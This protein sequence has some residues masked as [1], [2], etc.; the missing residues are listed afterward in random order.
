MVENRHKLGNDDVNNNVIIHQEL[1]DR[2]V[3]LKLFFADVQWWLITGIAHFTIYS[4]TTLPEF[5]L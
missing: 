3:I 1:G 5:S 2:K 4:I